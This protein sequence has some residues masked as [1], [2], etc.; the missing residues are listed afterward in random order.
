MS[1]DKPARRGIFACL[2]FSL[3]GVSKGGDPKLG[4]WS[5][6]KTFARLQVDIWVDLWYGL[7]RQVRIDGGQL[8]QVRLR[9]GCFL[10]ALG[11]DLVHHWSLDFTDASVAQEFR[12]SNFVV[13]GSDSPTENIVRDI[14]G[15]RQM[16]ARPFANGRVRAT[17]FTLNEWLLWA[18]A[19]DDWQGPSGP[20]RTKIALLERPIVL[21]EGEVKRVFHEVR[22][23]QSRSVSVYNMR[24]LQF[25]LDRYG[26][27]FGAVARGE[28]PEFHPTG[29]E[30]QLL[31]PNV[32]DA[33]KGELQDALTK[34]RWLTTWPP[35]D[36]RDVNRVVV[37]D[38][39][40][41]GWG[42]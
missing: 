31:L 8:E 1:G 33:R 29:I 42:E 40:W 20:W 9:R 35:W 22:A 10:Q 23:R 2:R 13:V 32:G 19:V 25:E 5:F 24:F 36:N 3:T 4:F 34:P 14:E 28:A 11:A 38:T 18:S 16:L 17:P 7:Y 26:S 12:G 6:G 37:Q 15:A 21:T 41:H 27:Y 30:L 39:W